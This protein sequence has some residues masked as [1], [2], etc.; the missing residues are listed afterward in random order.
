MEKQCF[1]LNVLHATVKN[2]DVLK[3]KQVDYWAK[4]PLSDILF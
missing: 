3:D 2:Q 1:C 4:T